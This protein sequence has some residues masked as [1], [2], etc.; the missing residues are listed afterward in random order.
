MSRISARKQTT[1]A[2]LVVFCLIPFIRLGE[3]DLQSDEVLY[4]NRAESIVASGNLF[5]ETPL[6]AFFGG[7]PPLVI[8]GMALA[9][10]LLGFSSF[11]AR[12]VSAISAAGIVLVIY[13]FAL[14]ILPQVY[15]LGA[16]ALLASS[17]IFFRFSQL[18]QLDIPWILFIAVAFAL[19]WYSREL[20]KR[21]LFVLAAV[22]FGLSFVA[23]L[24]VSI[25]PL[26]VLLLWIVLESRRENPVVRIKDVI[27]F[28]VI[29]AIIALPWHIWMLVHYGGE[30]YNVMIRQNVVMRATQGGEATVKETGKLFY[31]N[32]LVVGFP[33]CVITSIFFLYRAVQIVRARSLQSIQS[34]ELFLWIWLLVPLIA[35]SIAKAEMQSYSAQMLPPLAL[36]TMLGVMEFS[37][38]D[39]GTWWRPTALIGAIAACAWGFSQVVRDG[40][41]E[42]FAPGSA[43]APVSDTLFII[44]ASVVIICAAIMVVVSLQ[45]KVLLKNIF[46]L[47][48]TW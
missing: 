16:A 36:L 31:I 26:G 41:R 6:K 24:F 14:L 23:K 25:I 33:L 47:V 18:A 22:L 28:L 12:L 10:K 27:Q 29:I 15:A 30:A 44:A 5:P 2:A 37:R 7:Q 48:P 46:L 45:K 3:G 8:W 38:A 1:I 21:S 39:V 34:L 35:L 9:V 13:W 40:A 20:E 17:S 32:Q 11:S 42:F 4:A 19:F 43:R